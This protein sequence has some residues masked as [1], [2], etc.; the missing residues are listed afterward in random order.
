VTPEAQRIAIAEACGK[1]HYLG[2]LE[3]GARCTK[4][5]E[6]INDNVHKVGDYL[7]DLN[8]IHEAEKV[9]DEKQQA[10]FVKH[11]ENIVSR[12]PDAHLWSWALLHATAAQRA[13]ALLRTL[14]LW[15]D[16]K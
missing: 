9:L 5:G 6:L 11:L 8:A 15:D 4:C 10:I 3:A 1:H 16:N 7:F 14:N 13:E 2:I 12:D